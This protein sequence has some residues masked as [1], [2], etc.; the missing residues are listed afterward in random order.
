MVFR[1]RGRDTRGHQ[2]IT[3]I[4]RFLVG[5]YR[6]IEVSRSWSFKPKTTLQLLWCIFN[7]LLPLQSLPHQHFTSQTREEASAATDSFAS[8]LQQ[9]DAPLE[10]FYVYSAKYGGPA[11]Q[12]NN[13]NNDNNN[14]D[15]NNNNNNN[16]FFYNN[17]NNNQL[18][19]AR[20]TRDST[21]TE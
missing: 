16:N 5:E 19:L 10:W 21:S 13:D 14:N 20:V 17:N 12:N 1:L 3:Y 2:R 11:R 4:A 6:I 18:Y 9:K 7:P 8:P 15:D